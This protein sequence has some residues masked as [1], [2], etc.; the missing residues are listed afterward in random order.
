M[1]YSVNPYEEAQCQIECLLEDLG[2]LL[3]HLS[4]MKNV[5]RV[6]CVEIKIAME[7][8]ELASIKLGL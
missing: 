6:V 7:A 5:D 4:E 2:H 3:V 8:V 1:R